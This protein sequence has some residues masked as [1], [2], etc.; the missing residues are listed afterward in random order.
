M[1]KV[2]EHAKAVARE[3]I[4]AGLLH[5]NTARQLYDEYQQFITGNVRGS[6]TQLLLARGAI[7][8]GGYDHLERAVPPPG[9]DDDSQEL[10]DTADLPSFKRPERSDR[11][12][13]LE[14]GLPLD[15]GTDGDRVTDDSDDR[16]LTM[17]Y[18]EVLAT[19]TSAAIS[20]GSHARPALGPGL[21]PQTGASSTMGFDE[22]LEAP[23]AA[24]APA[25]APAPA[26]PPAPAQARTGWGS[27]VMRA[28]NLDEIEGRN[29]GVI[30]LGQPD[31]LGGVF[32]G[33]GLLPVPG[34]D[35]PFRSGPMVAPSTF[36][37]PRPAD[38]TAG[39]SRSRSGQQIAAGSQSGL[40]GSLPGSSRP[41]GLDLAPDSEAERQAEFFEI[42]SIADAG[43]ASEFD[44]VAETSEPRVGDVFGNFRLLSELGRGGMGVIYKAESLKTPGEMFALKTLNAG[45]GPAAAKRRIRFQREVEALRRL[46]HPNI[47]GVHDCGR[48]GV[49]D[50]YVMDYIQGRE[51]KAAIK[52]DDL[53]PREK[54]DIFIQICE[55]VHHAHERNVIHRDLKPANVLVDGEKNSHVLDFG[56][57]KL[58]DESLELTRTGAAL[59]TPYYMAPEQ[60]Q[61]P[62]DVDFRVDIFAL[63]VILFELMT[64]ARPFTGETA[65]EVTNKIMNEE[66]P[67]PSSVNPKLR[68]ALDAICLKAMEKDAARR[69]QSTDELRREVAKYRRGD[70]VRDASDTAQL[71]ATVRRYVDRHKVPL[72][73]GFAVGFAIAWAI[74]PF[75]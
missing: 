6:F 7:D 63:G 34:L 18:E 1:S 30:S 33:P 14:P 23:R 38:S 73:I 21:G 35:D 47:V 62:K 48:K 58:S 12:A 46:T 44:S 15:P 28:P 69:Y 41:D 67:K 24:P 40:S 31:P 19:P 20:S 32:G 8:A 13:E 16:E 65:G 5:P 72:L 70:R 74:R 37:P 71:K 29:S 53:T 42:D 39:D 66:P 22:V 27:T 51:L 50:F 11:L 43:A 10:I 61:N 17:N 45:T 25:L 57:A 36:E 54:L 75:F 52:D 68:P 2:G 60:I 3:A 55:A 56:L 49:Y 4:R 26:P 9:P 59:G 64:G